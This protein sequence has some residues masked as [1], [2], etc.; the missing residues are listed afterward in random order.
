MRCTWT[1]VIAAAIVLAAVVAPLAGANG[2]MGGTENASLALPADGTATVTRAPMPASSTVGTVTVKATSDD[3]SFLDTLTT[4][5]KEDKP[6]FGARAVHCVLLYARLVSTK[7]TDV[8]G[9]EETAHSL[10]DLFLHICLQIALSLSP[11]SGAASHA[12]GAATTARCGMRNAAVSVSITKT[13]SGYTAILH[14]TPHTSKPRRLRVSCT[15]TATG[16]KITERA[17]KARGKL[18]KATGPKLG[19]GFLSGSSSA[20]N[21]KIGLGV[22]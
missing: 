16:L 17:H 3:H 12:A 6:T 5:L 10:D 15:H 4:T 11:Q 21:L 2:P 8:S 19:V 7:Y 1:A 20:G 14:G 18:A 22:R 13:G 9:D